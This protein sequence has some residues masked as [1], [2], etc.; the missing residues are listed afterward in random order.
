M[1]VVSSGETRGTAAA[2]L[3]SLRYLLPWLHPD[4]IQVAV[5]GLQTIPVVDHDAVSVDPQKIGK[6]DLA[7]IRSNHGN[8]GGHGEIEAKM[9]LLVD[10]GALVVVS[11]VVGELRLDFGIRQLAKRLAPEE[12][13]LGLAAQI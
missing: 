6:D 1:E 12:A 7:V 10:L 3:L 9:V 8:V 2:D 13:R 5:D 11:A 4:R